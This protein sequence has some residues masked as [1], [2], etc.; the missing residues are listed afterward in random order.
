LSQE[1]EAEAAVKK[2]KE[3]EEAMLNPAVRAAR[4]LAEK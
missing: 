1:A 2:K 3:D 4:E